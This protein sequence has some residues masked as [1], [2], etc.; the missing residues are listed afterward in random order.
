MAT[1]RGGLG[2]FEICAESRR[3]VDTTTRPFPGVVWEHITAGDVVSRWGVL[4]APTGETATLAALFLENVHQRMAFPSRN[5]RAD[6]GFEFATEFE[7]A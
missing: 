3:N 7:Q 6:G 2:P 4:P 1:Y 5:T